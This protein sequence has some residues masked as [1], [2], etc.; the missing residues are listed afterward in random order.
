M[1]ITLHSGT[2]GLTGLRRVRETIKLSARA[3][4]H[5]Q[6]VDGWLQLLNSSPLFTDLVA[7]HPRMVYKIFR[8]YFSNTMGYA[9]R[10]TL[11]SEHYRF[12]LRQGLGPLTALASKDKVV[13]ARVTGKGG[14]PYHIQLAAVEPMEREG[15][16]V[17]QLVASSTPGDEQEQEQTIVYNCAF[18]FHQGERGMVLGV[19]CMQ[20]PRGDHGLQAIKDATR[21]LHGL[22]PKNMMVKL[23]GQIGYALGCS[24]LRLV[25]NANRTV[26]RSVRQ[27]KV[28][29]DYDALW[30]ELDA[31]VRA[32]GDY[33]L[34]CEPLA[35]P[36]LA[37]IASKKRSEAR[38]RHETLATLAEAITAS[39]RAARQ[40]LAGSMLETPVASAHDAANDAANEHEAYALA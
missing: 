2:T 21:E 19:G 24:E 3:M 22:R 23:L 17:L 38:K 35:E 4:L 11:L 5:R 10:L 32:D 34:P 15:E 26:C 27:G 25:G 39:L 13:L 1:L 18:S 36:D 30:Q 16:L 7:D 14:L 33:R 6:A 8:P 31:T 20:G 40:P 29:A 12:I 9:A 37:A 28:H